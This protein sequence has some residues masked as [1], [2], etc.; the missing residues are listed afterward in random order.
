[1]FRTGAVDEGSRCQCLPRDDNTRYYQCMCVHLES[2][3]M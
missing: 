2:G 1:M 3:C